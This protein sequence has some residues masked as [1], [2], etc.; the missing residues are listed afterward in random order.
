MFYKHISIIILFSLV[1]MSCEDA[2]KKNSMI[3]EE[4]YVWQQHPSFFR[5]DK[6]LLNSH[7]YNDSLYVVGVNRISIF[8]TTNDNPVINGS[9]GRDPNI[10]QAPA[11]GG[12]LIALPMDSKYQVVVYSPAFMSCSGSGG[13]YPFGKSLQLSLLTNEYGD[14]A[15]VVDGFY[16]QSFGAI[17]DYNQLIMMVDDSASTCYNCYTSFALVNLNP[18]TDNGYSDIPCLNLSPSVRRI[19]Y[20]SGMSIGLSSVIAYKEKFLISAPRGQYEIAIIDTSGNLTVSTDIQ[21]GVSTFFV[22]GDTVLAFTNY[23]GNLYHSTNGSDWTFWFGNLPPYDL[24]FFLVQDKLC[25]YIYSQLFWLDAAN[26]QIEELDNEGLQSNE[27]NSVNVF[28]NK[29]WITTLSGLFTKP[30]DRFFD[31]KPVTASKPTY[32]HITISDNKLK[33]Y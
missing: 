31:V 28:H 23:T 3:P 5:L 27:I 21:G 12:R 16:R 22:K 6:I 25:F 19:P 9:L 17:N 2:S 20:Q 29:V 32:R 14:G 18:E 24:R 11:V 4:D 13:M 1:V 30:L 15:R 33:K 8:D 26:L 10:T 7:V